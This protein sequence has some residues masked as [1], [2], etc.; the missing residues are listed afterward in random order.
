M[1][2]QAPSD[3]IE[4]HTSA[5]GLDPRQLGR[6]ARMH[7]HKDAEGHW[8][9]RSERQSQR[10]IY[11]AIA[12]V[13]MG[14]S[15]FMSLV[16]KGNEAVIYGVCAALLL[17]LALVLLGYREHLVFAPGNLIRRRSF[18]GR[19]EKDIE[20]WPAGAVSLVAVP[21]VQLD[22]GCWLSV[23]AGKRLSRY[24]IGEEAETLTLAKLLAAQTGAMAMERIS[25][26]PKARPIQAAGAFEGEVAP[27]RHPGAALRADGKADS[28]PAVQTAFARVRGS[29]W[30]ALLPLPVFIALGTLLLWLGY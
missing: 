26:Y 11:G 27:D 2:K 19:G 15:L 22:K 13:P 23:E 6:G 1:M 24:S 12:L 16:L 29:F 20:R 7:L 5:Q 18:W 10:V 17:P 14:A 21:L 8:Y 4:P 28:K 3:V 9:F 25:E 30:R